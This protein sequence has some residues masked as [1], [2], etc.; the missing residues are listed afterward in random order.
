[1]TFRWSIKAKLSFWAYAV[2]SLCVLQPGSASNEVFSL[3][4]TLLCIKGVATSYSPYIFGPLVLLVVQ[5]KLGCSREPIKN[6]IEL[7][8]V[9]IAM[10]LV[11]ENLN[12][13]FGLS[14]MSRLKEGVSPWFF[15]LLGNGL[16]N[17]A[18]FPHMP[19]FPSVK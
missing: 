7:V 15:S 16:R 17:G 9:S 6:C 11:V 14:E 12:W 19:S 18:G 2:L 5:D 4:C 1:M 3:L 8:E 10:G 13:P